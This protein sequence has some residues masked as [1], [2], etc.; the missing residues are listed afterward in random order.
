[1]STPRNT[2]CPYCKEPTLPN[3]VAIKC[4]DCKTLFH[5]D[6]WRQYGKCSIY[7]CSGKPQIME[8][9]NSEAS[10]LKQHMKTVV[11]YYVSFPVTL[12]AFILFARYTD[13]SSFWYAL[14]LLWVLTVGFYPVIRS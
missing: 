11:L 7:G 5:S 6:C 12:A 10:V 9:G 1:M 13:L 8:L 4:S 14:G 3:G 2:V